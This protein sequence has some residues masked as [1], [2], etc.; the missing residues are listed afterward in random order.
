[1][2]SGHFRHLVKFEKRNMLNE[3]VTELQKSAL[4][5]NIELSEATLG[6]SFFLKKL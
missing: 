3:K 2:T 6:P 5:I 4:L 1:M